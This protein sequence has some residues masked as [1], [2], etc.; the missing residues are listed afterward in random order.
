MNELDA[1]GQLGSYSALP[2]IFFTIA[3]TAVV[4]LAFL[5]QQEEIE[6]QSSEFKRLAKHQEIQ[7]FENNFYQLLNTYFHTLDSISYRSSI[8]KKSKDKEEEYFFEHKSREALRYLFEYEFKPKVIDK[9]IV[10]YC[11]NPRESF[12]LYYE[13]FLVSG[14]DR[15]GHYFRVVFHILKVINQN[16]LLFPDEGKFYSNILRAQLSSH[17][18]IF[19]FF[20]GISERAYFGKTDKITFEFLINKY[21][22]LEH[23]SI[24]KY[25]SDD[26]NDTKCEVRKLLG[27][28]DRNA[29][30]DRADEILLDLSLNS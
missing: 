8:N 12:N 20:N 26:E 11:D 22:F 2:L 24:S 27:Y 23:L 13:N 29:Y 4:F 15:L 25:I 3:G 21:A 17:E 10:P 19:L 28:Y 1:I 5:K 7:D 16:R 30:G 14:L 18:I 9:L 6:N